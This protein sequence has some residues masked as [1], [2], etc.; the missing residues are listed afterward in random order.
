MT[1]PEVTGVIERPVQLVTTTRA[2]NY[3]RRRSDRDGI[4]GVVEVFALSD[5]LGVGVGPHPAGLA[6]VV[7]CAGL[8]A[9][10]A[11]L[12][13]LG[14]G[15]ELVKAIDDFVAEGELLFAPVVVTGQ[16]E[17]EAV[18]GGAFPSC[19]LFSSSGLGAWINVTI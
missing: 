4:D 19:S 1:D 15:E 6:G 18:D 17:F 7:D 2:L 10:A 11:R 13:D 5:E 12:W 16:L 3:E 14:S 9:L 8:P